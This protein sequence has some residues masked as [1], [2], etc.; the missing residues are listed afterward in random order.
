MQI[1]LL[2]LP[3]AIFALIVFRYTSDQEGIEAAKDRIKAHL[4][5]L[6]LY[7]DDLLVTLRA[8]GKILRYNGTYLR[9]A[10]VPMAVMIVPFVL[11]I[12]QIESRFVYRSLAPGESAILTVTVDGEDPVSGL[13]ASLALPDEVLQETPALRIDETAEIVWRVRAESPG[14]YRVGIRLGEAELFKRVVVDGRHARVSPAVYRS[15]DLNTLA[16]PAESALA[17]DA[18]IRAIHL[19]YPP[20]R[21]AFAGL[22]SASWIFFGASLVFGF[23]LRGAFGVTF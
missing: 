1:V 18:P 20:V 3:A 9:H 13:E 21:A 6:R 15:N 7:K 10:L 14:D 2:G 8:Q 22:S 4:L 16:Y 19:S 11:M 5:E 12:I 17:S 23:A